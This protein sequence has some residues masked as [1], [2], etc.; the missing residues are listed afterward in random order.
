M[1]EE[2]WF[3]LLEEYNPEITEEQ[4]IELVQD[5]SVFRKDSL[6]TFACMLAARYPSCKTMAEDFGRP[7]NF[8]NN[9]IWQTGRRVYNKINCSIMSKDDGGNVYW[10]VCCMGHQ[11]GDEGFHFKI[12][13]E[14]MSAFKKTG[15]LENVEIKEFNLNDYLSEGHNIW[16]GG[17]KWD[18]EYKNDEFI[19]NN[20]WQIGWDRNDENRWAKES[21]ER[22]EEIKDNDLFLFKS[23]GGHNDLTIFHIGKVISKDNEKI[24]LK[25]ISG[26]PFYKGKA[27]RLE[28]GGWFGTLC[29]IT[30]ETAINKLFGLNNDNKDY[31]YYS[32]YINLLKKN[33]NIILHGAPGTGKTFL[34]R[35]IAN[36]M[37]CPDD[38]IVF[39]QFHPSY[40]YT[41]FVEGLRPDK[42][43]GFERVDGVFKEFC[44]KALNKTSDDYIDNFEIVWGKLIELLNDKEFLD[45]PLLS[46]RTSIKIELN[47]YGTGLVNRA[48]ADSEAEQ[49]H[50]WIQGKSKFFNKEQI[51]NIYR[52]LPGV[53]QGGFDNY[54]KAIVKYMKD[55]LGLKDYFKGTDKTLETQQPFVFIIDE[56]NRGELSKIFGEL[57]F[58]IDPGYRGEKG[59]IQTQYQNLIETGDTYGKGFYIPENVYIIGTMNDIDRSV[60]SMDFAMRRRFAFVEVTAEESAKNM[61]LSDTSINKM[62]AI[63]NELK[64]IDGLNKSYFIGGAYFLKAD[65]K[66][67][68][69][70]KLS[71]EELW[72][73]HLE[74]LIR[75]YLRG[76]MPSDE[77]ESKL[78]SIKSSYDKA[79]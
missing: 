57:F 68:E 30:G 74:G 48:Y 31:I 70:E 23:Y 16:A 43:G 52:G 49:N 75:E 24:Y 33:K 19:N 37:G 51:Y 46:G 50:N 44:K 76:I 26:L 78:I 63:N 14:L 18:D 45:V 20:Y 10:C 39:V 25:T 29:K 69:D 2:K 47:E 22:F 32:K 58:T 35:G 6:I 62:T 36:A 12:R 79:E 8:Y 4:W 38:N 64:D 7:L 15:V 42:N 3:P 61:N 13:P 40:D 21:W 53:P 73:Y 54:R 1:N 9:G 60:E 67:K 65:D 66:N 59:L 72:N 56:I 34:A 71:Y 11:G 27:P 41:D 28:S 5:E 55:N 77:I 17:C